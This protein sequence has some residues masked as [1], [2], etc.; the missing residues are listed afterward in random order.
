[1]E[2]SVICSDF[3]DFFYLMVYARVAEI[4]ENQPA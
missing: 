1:M 4:S 2:T 3:M